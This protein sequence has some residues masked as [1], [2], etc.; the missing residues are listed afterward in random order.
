MPG[1]SSTTHRDV[2]N[3]FSWVFPIPAFGHGSIPDST[4]LNS[5][6]FLATSSKGK[7]KSIFGSRTKAVEALFKASTKLS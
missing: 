6:K 5:Q 1:L 2:F 7:Q 4:V 3:N